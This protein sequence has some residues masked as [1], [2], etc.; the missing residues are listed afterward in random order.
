MIDPSQ[1]CVFYH[2]STQKKEGESQE[3]LNIYEFKAKWRTFMNAKY[4]EKKGL[5]KCIVEKP[6]FPNR[7]Q[8]EA[9]DFI[10]MWDLHNF[11]QYKDIQGTPD[12]IEDTSEL[13]KTDNDL[14]RSEPMPYMNLE[15]SIYQKESMGCDLSVGSVSSFDPDHDS[16]ECITKWKVE[17][18]N[19]KICGSKEKHILLWCRWDVDKSRWDVFEHLQLD[20]PIMVAEF[21]N[22][23]VECYKMVRK[24]ETILPTVKKLIKWDDD[25]VHSEIA[26]T[27]TKK[28]EVDVETLQDCFNNHDDLFT[29]TNYDD[30]Q[31]FVEGMML[32]NI[33]C[34][35]CKRNLSELKI[36][37]N[38]P[39]KVCS[40]HGNRG[41][42]ECICYECSE[43]MLL[44]CDSRK[45]KRS[46]GV[47]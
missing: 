36:S 17:K 27:K 24:Y 20:Y 15:T 4:M 38:K 32:Y 6:Q 44:N 22:K 16:L 47:N 12:T 35:L 25:A 21:L 5:G 29:Y 7:I 34:R 8:E 45:R 13:V 37:M 40:N 42:C 33:P 3:Y 14:T 10:S 18:K 43:Q 31:W 19:A 1:M 28:N 30:A 41:C 23:Y 9:N 2:H 39:A 26:S 11:V 46:G